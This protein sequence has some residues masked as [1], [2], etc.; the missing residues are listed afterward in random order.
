[1]L[2]QIPQKPVITSLDL[3]AVFTDLTKALGTVNREALWVI[4]SK[5]G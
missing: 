1:M 5:R 4:L 3:V 2:D